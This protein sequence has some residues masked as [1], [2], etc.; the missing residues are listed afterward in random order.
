MQHYLDNQGKDL[1]LK[2]HSDPFTQKVTSIFQKYLTIPLDTSVSKPL[3]QV[4]HQVLCH[5]Q[6]DLPQPDGPLNAVIS[7]LLIF[8]LIFFKA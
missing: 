6:V 4:V 1:V 5:Q 7:S 3:D 8:K 2:Y